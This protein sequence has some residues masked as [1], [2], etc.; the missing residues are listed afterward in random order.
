VAAGVEVV[1]R[2]GMLVNSVVIPSPRPEL[3]RDIL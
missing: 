1:S 2:E 3:I